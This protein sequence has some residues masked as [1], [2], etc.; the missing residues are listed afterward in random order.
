LIGNSIGKPLVELSKKVKKFGEGDLTQKFEVKGRDEIAR[1]SE[2][3]NIMAKNITKY[4]KEVKE[5]SEELEEMSKEIDI[6]LE[7]QTEQMIQI[8][9]SAGNIK[10]STITTASSVEEI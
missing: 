4:L 5:S 9:E 2:S 6:N 3:L 8:D 10:R 1:I 7:K